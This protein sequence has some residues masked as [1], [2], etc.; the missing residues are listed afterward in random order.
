MNSS[1]SLGSRVELCSERNRLSYLLGRISRRF[2]H[3]RMQARTMV[4]DSYGIASIDQRIPNAVMHIKISQDAGV[5]CLR[6]PLILNDKPVEIEEDAIQ[7][8]SFH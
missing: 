6:L 7:V 4:V 1:D 2:G 5:T 3:N 8:R